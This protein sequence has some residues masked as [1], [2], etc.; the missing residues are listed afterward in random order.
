MITKNTTLKKVLEL[1]KA[2][3][4][5]GHCC[6]HGSGAL[7]EGDL[8]KIAKFLETSEKELKK[9]CLEE[10]EKFNTKRLRPVTVKKDKPYGRCVFFNK[11]KGCVIHQVKPLECKTG[12]C[13][14]HGEDLS[15][16]FT[17]N[18]YLNADDPGSVRQ[19][20][21]YLKSG[22]KTL[23]GGKLD[24]VV[25]DKKTLKKILEYKILR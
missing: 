25:P 8:K 21:A 13:S 23:K 14:E 6:S 22:G 4:K 15:L 24:E 19:Y 18:Y 11:E 5:C 2:C 1:G 3:K 10:I 17:L 20:A 7:D 16:W 12:N 9:T